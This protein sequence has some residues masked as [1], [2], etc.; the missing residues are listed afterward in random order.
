MTGYIFINKSVKV[1]INKSI[2]VTISNFFHI[3]RVIKSPVL[4]MSL[5]NILYVGDKCRMPIKSQSLFAQ[6]H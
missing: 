2:K 3:F 6:S 4:I 1:T 5:K